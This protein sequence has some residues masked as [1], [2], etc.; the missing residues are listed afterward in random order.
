MTLS[1]PET[2]E[3]I[4]RYIGEGL[5]NGYRIRLA[6]GVTLAILLWHDVLHMEPS[7][8]LAPGLGSFSADL[9][10]ITDDGDGTP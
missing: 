9:R 1:V 4:D 5:S 10:A 2:Y 8:D 3:K 6:G 7:G